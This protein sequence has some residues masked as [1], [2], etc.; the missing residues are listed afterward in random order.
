MHGNR[1]AAGTRI[2]RVQNF[3]SMIMTDVISLLQSFQ[4]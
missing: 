4:L 2:R 1:W 3:L